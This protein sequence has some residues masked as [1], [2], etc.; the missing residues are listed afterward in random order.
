[1]VHGHVVELLVV[2]TILILKYIV[3]KAVMNG[4]NITATACN[5][6]YNYVSWDGMQTTEA[7]KKVVAD[8]IRS[9]NYSD[10]PS[11]L[12]CT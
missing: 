12:Y 5:D 9:G 2:P 1:M 3:E 8:A 10:P 6:P 4:K 7:A 11:R